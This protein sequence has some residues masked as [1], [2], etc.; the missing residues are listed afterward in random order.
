MLNTIVFPLRMVSAT[1]LSLPQDILVG[2]QSKTFSAHYRRTDGCVDI[3][4][5][6]F[7]MDWRKQMLPNLVGWVFSTVGR[8]WYFHFFLLVLKLTSKKEKKEFHRINESR[9]WRILGDSYRLEQIKDEN[10]LTLKFGRNM[11]S[12]DAY[13]FRWKPSFL[14]I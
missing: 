4:S 7:S 3:I 5:L 11:C 6:S 10:I 14:I 1:L 2:P 13:V 12:F 9:L 8:N